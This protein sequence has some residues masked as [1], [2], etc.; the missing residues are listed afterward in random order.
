MSL[1]VALQTAN[2]GL[3][4]AQASLN[5]I[6]DNIANVNT[7]GYVRKVVDQ[8]QLVVDGMGQGVQING[9]KRIT[10]QY[11]Q[12]ASLSASSDASR[13]SSYS[14]FLTNAQGLFG[15]PSSGKTDFFFNW[16]DQIYNDFA[17][18][19]NDPSSSLLRTQAISDTQEFLGESDRIN[20]Q[21][22]Q[23][24]KTVDGQVTDVVSQ[25][26]DLLSQIDKLNVDITRAKLVNADASGAENIQQSLVNQLS[27]LMSVQVAGRDQGGVT[28]RSADGVML[29]GNGAATLTYAGSAT[30]PGYITATGA[31]PGSMPQAINVSSGQLRGLLDLRNTTLPGLSNQLGEFVG[32]M[33][34]QLNAVSNASTAFPA[35]GVLTG[36]NTGLDLPTAIGGFTGQTTVAIT[37]SAGVVQGQVAIDF[38]A[39]TMSVNGGAASATLLFPSWAQVWSS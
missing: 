30:T 17:S 3:L 37:N 32:R 19:A 38:D 25:A 8:Q 31:G 22:G 29:A 5:A 39:G 1:S 11:L 28:V 9:V 2:T 27:S 18:A 35:P 36:R 12:S 20:T 16:S 14:S 7:P 10:D 4:A 24:G 23:L 15:N 26:N 33:T 21:I 34:D 13:W 6:S